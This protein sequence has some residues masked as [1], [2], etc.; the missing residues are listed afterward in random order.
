MRFIDTNVFL[1]YVTGDD[2]DKAAA[3]RQ[4][5]ERVDA[6]E[7]KVVTT[8]AIIAEIVFVLRSKRHY[9]VPA[10]QVRD[11]LAPIIA[12]PAL[13]LDHKKAFLRALDLMATHP[14]LDFE[15]ALC[16]LHMQRQAI[17]EIYSYDRDFDLIDDLERLEPGSTR[18]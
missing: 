3:S 17:G 1:R 7:E 18:G 10:P 11:L 5:I 4:L 14:A 16:A 6:G 8:E 13:L 9:N 2:T 12:M 15:D